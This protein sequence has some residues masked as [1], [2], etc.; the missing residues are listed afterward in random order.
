M[1]TRTKN[2]GRQRIPTPRKIRLKIL[3][4]TDM[5]G[6]SGITH[7]DQVVCGRREWE[8]ARAFLTGDVNAAVRGVYNAAEEKGVKAEEVHVTVVDS[9][10]AMNNILPEHLD[11]RV[12]RLIRGIERKYP[13]VEGID[14]TYNGAIALANH[15]QTPTGENERVGILPH[16]W[17]P[18]WRW[19]VNGLE[20]SETI[21]NAYTCAE[22][23]VPLLMVSGDDVIV[24]KV[25]RFMKIREP[26]REFDGVPKREVEGAIVKE[27]YGFQSGATMSIN[28][29]QK[30]IEEAAF[31]AVRRLIHQGCA[32]LTCKKHLGTVI[33]EL[34]LPED[35]KV[36]D[37]KMVDG[38]Y[39]DVQKVG[40]LDMGQN[41][42]KV[43][44][45]NF[46]EAILTGGAILNTFYAK[47]LA[48]LEAS[49]DKLQY[50]FLQ[51]KL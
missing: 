1:K 22:H 37:I 48:E 10:W 50:E 51:S 11:D 33:L 16:T 44:A 49:A 12:K 19:I 34:I 40:I 6:G 23:E 4:E 41:K 35:I 47:K 45:E 18:G 25:L 39:D 26:E 46:K 20:V 7:L 38:R 29:A 43:I 13:Q 21:L 15:D 8:R 14:S 2:P 17:L 42:V 24:E 5:E 3:I 30:V 27:A 9:H 32:Q 31:N 28:E 36:A